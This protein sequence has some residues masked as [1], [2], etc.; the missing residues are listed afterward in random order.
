MKHLEKIDENDCHKTKAFMVIIAKNIAI[1]MYN[2]RKRDNEVFFFEET[3]ESDSSYE[4]SKE[5]RDVQQIV[6][7]IK[8]LPELYIHIMMLR[9]LYEYSDKECAELLK[10][11]EAAA[12][13]RL[14]RG[15]GLLKEQLEKEAADDAKL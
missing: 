1:N 12:R 14:E 7:C 10:L 5:D 4:S 11:S 9:Y 2:K 6:Q 8:K 3:V 13:K 15:R